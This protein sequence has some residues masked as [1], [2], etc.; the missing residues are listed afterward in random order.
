MTVDIDEEIGKSSFIGDEGKRISHFWHLPVLNHLLIRSY[1]PNSYKSRIQ[2]DQIYTAARHYC[3]PHSSGLQRW[4]KIHRQSWHRLAGA[5]RGYKR[6]RWC[7]ANQANR[8]S[9]YGKFQKWFVGGRSDIDRI[10]FV[11]SR[12]WNRNFKRSP[13]TIIPAIHAG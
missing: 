4:R 3:C 13:T 2:C 10:E 12:F 8:Y 9:I 6:R 11:G 1:W 7:C 5:C